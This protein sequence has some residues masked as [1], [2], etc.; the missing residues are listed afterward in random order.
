M[1]PFFTSKVGFSLF[2]K[3]VFSEITS[4]ILLIVTIYDNKV[5]FPEHYKALDLVKGSSQDTTQDITE[6]T[7]E[8]TYME[9]EIDGT[10]YQLVPIE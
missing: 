5:V 7:T 10:K 3:V 6:P 9:T 8:A 1:S 2:V 4:L